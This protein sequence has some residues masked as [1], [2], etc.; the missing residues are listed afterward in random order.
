[1]RAIKVTGMLASGSLKQI[2]W[3][4]EGSNSLDCTAFAAGHW[5]LKHTLKN[6]G[7]IQFNLMTQFLLFTFIRNAPGLFESFGFVGVKPAFIAF[8]LFGAVSAPLN[9]V[10]MC[11]PPTLP[12]M[13]PFPVCLSS[14]QIHPYVQ[15][16]FKRCFLGIPIHFL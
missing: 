1:M 14:F 7:I 10:R 5:K 15:F 16:C 12:L 2:S 13:I 4:K 3:D 11:S 6:L 8:T 9:E